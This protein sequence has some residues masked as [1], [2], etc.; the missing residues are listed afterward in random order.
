MII[1]IFNVHL[2]AAHLHFQWT[3]SLGGRR[4]H[5]RPGQ[6]KFSCPRR[7]SNSRRSKSRH[8][9]E[10]NRK[11]M[12]GILTYEPAFD[13]KITENLDMFLPSKRLINSS[14]SLKRDRRPSFPASKWTKI[15]GTLVC[16]HYCAFHK[17]ANSEVQKPT[18]DCV[19]RCR[20]SS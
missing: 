5:A 19:F 16:I 3:F 1:I 11:I 8:S 17:H 20:Q 7:E 2:W 10:T 6:R 14:Q 12:A 15:L 9:R 13:R 18:D 4:N